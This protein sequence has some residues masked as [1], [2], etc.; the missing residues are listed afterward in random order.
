MFG[1]RAQR[2][3]RSAMSLDDGSVHKNQTNKILAITFPIISKTWSFQKL[4]AI[5][6]K[7]FAVTLAATKNFTQLPSNFHN[8]WQTAQMAEWYRASVSSAVDLA[9]IPSRVKPMT[10]NIGIHSFPA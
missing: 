2:Q 7:Q 4:L 5:Q 8:F 9:L 6:T 3:F 10:L 1:F